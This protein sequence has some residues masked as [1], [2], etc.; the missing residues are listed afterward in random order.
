M[1]SQ[2]SLPT[3]V[4]YKITP[5][6]MWTCVR[7]Q[8]Q[9]WG[10]EGYQVPRKYFDHEQ[11]KWE[12]KRAEILRNHRRVWPP[13]DWPKDKETEKPIMPIRKNYIDDVI[14]LA[15]SFNEPGKSEELKASLESRGT[16]KMPE[17]KVPINMRDKFLK[18]EQE[19]KEKVASLPKIQEW[20]VNAIEDAQ[21]NIEEMKSKERNKLDVYKERYTKEKPLWPRCD[22]VTIVAD[23]E[24]VGEQI[25]FYNS[26]AKQ[27]E[28]PDKNKLFMPRK[29]VT[30]RRAPVWSLQG[31]NPTKLPTENMIARD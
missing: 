10:I 24:Y 20:K 21:K 30:M 23:S 19:R 22:R 8:T 27:G 13:N 18:E 17:P 3:K 26:Y 2:D 12:I 7:G 25:P 29:E 1:K 11:Y 28:E 14:K 5:N 16:F 4:E 31:K 15:K 9:N 6:E